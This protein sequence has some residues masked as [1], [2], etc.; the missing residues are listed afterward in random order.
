M[1][2]HDGMI[3]IETQDKRWVL[4]IKT[5]GKNRFHPIA[6]DNPPTRYLVEYSPWHL[7]A[8]GNVIG[9]IK[10]GCVKLYKIY[11]WFW[12]RHV[13]KEL[14]KMLEN[15]EIYPEASVIIVPELKIG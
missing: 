10:D 13:Y 3:T 5:Q 11:T 14:K 4:G 6:E 15:P 2:E 8:H 1:L 12:N 9:T 7:S